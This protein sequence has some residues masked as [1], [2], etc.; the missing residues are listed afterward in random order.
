MEVKSNVYTKGD[1]KRFEKFL[2]EKGI[3]KDYEEASLKAS[4]A[5]QTFDEFKESVLKGQ[6]DYEND[7]PRELIKSA[8]VWRLSKEGFDYWADMTEQFMSWWRNN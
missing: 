5:R 1:L 2:N 7:K 6:I 4:Y 8:F 3:L